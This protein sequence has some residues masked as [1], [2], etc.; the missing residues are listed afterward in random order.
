[1]IVES[2]KSQDLQSVCWRPRTSRLK[3]KGL[4]TRRLM[5]QFQSKSWW[6][7]DPEDQC[8]SWSLKEAEKLMS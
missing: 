4:G 2:D 5:V 7:R 3:S 8:F 1:M 6:A